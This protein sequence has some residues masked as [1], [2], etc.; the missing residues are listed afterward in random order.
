M[1]EFLF[2]LIGT[3]TFHSKI[4]CTCIPVISHVWLLSHHCNNLEW[5]ITL[6]NQSCLLEWQEKSIFIEIWLSDTKEEMTVL[7]E[8]PKF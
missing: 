8:D 5:P 7:F 2:I 4:V 3:L 6:H 1:N